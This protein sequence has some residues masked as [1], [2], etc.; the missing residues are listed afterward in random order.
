MTAGCIGVSGKPASVGPAGPGTPAISVTPTSVSFGTVTI[1]NTSSQAM[2][3]ANN[4]TA[5]LTISQVSVTGTGFS[6]STFPLPATVPA[7]QSTTLTANFKPASAGNVSGSISIVSNASATPM[8][9]SLSGAGQSSNQGSPVIAATPTSI[10]FGNVVVGNLTS[11]L[12]TVSNTGTANLTIS[13][14]TQSGTGFTWSGLSVPATLTPGQSANLSIDFDPATTG[15]QSGSIS[16]ASNAAGSPLVVSLT[17]TGT[18]A[19]HQLSANP[20]S[21]NFGNVAVGASSTLDVALTNTGNSNITISTVPVTGPGFSVSGG[22][23]V[24]LTPS[25]STNISVTLKPT[26]TGSASGN[27]SVTS[28]AQNSPLVIPLTGTGTQS[29][30]PSVALTWDPSASQV[31]GYFVYRKTGTTGSYAKLNT[32]FDPSTSY[33]DTSVSSNQTYTYYVTSVDSSNVESS[34]STPVTVTIP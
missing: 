13:S 30:P 10:N 1:G 27:V 34:P 6:Y 12:L 16:L 8:A 2:Q 4:G 23:G 18:A 14:L 32:A 20:T 11:E 17:G 19:T 22:A 29:A 24:T 5:D 7:G 9:I 26:V 25:Q 31:T 15:S 21:L 3:I 33:K 28:N